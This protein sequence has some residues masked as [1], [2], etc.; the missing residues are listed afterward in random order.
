MAGAHRGFALIIVLIAVSA[1]FA[2]A[3][4]A[5]TRSRVAV[6][7]A[8]ALREQARAQRNAR[9]AIAIAL[10]G[11]VP[12]EQGAGEALPPGEIGG[13]RFGETGGAGAGD[14]GDDGVELPELIKRLIPE[15]NELEQDLADEVGEQAAGLA[16]FASSVN[17]PTT[18][19]AEPSVLAALASVGLPRGPLEVELN[20]QRLT[21]E[22]SDAAGRLN[23]NTADFGQLR[24]YFLAVGLEGARA[25]AVSNQII[26]WRD[27]DSVPG[28][29]GAESDAYRLRGIT[30]R[31]APFS[32]LE[33][34]LYLPAMSRELFARI[35]GDLAT[36]GDG[37]IHL[38]SASEAVIASVEG[39]DAALARRIVEA[40]RERPLTKE[41][42]D[43]LVPV[44]RYAFRQRVRLN[45][46]GALRVDVA[47]HKP[48]GQPVAAFVAHAFITDRGVDAVSLVPR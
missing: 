31:D 19:P 43:E 38:P 9:A 32:T 4:P 20:G 10:R 17:L 18:S 15:L 7:E 28:D 5:A 42:F 46:T 21:L 3:L 1:L 36:A 24:R 11:L 33:E 40:R 29:A 2:L 16:R 37:T 25:T 39:G 30:C 27:E 41:V 14:A 8:S 44:R 34:L 6:V 45:P 23:I 47:V 48:Q 13:G 26:D 35:S 22:F 12:L